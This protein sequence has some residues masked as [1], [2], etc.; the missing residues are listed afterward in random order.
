V[1]S[2]YVDLQSRL[3]NLE[4]AETQLVRILEEAQDTQDVLDVF[5]QLTSIREQ[6]EVVKGQIKYY[7]ESASLSAISIRV[8]AQEKVEPIKIGP[9][10]PT[11]A[12]NDAIE[13]LVDF[14]HSFVEVF[15]YFVFNF[16][17]ELLL[18]VLVYGVP[19]WLIV[20]GL[21]NWRRRIRAKQAPAVTP[22]KK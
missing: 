20:R 11:G 12:F 5:D 8:I 16:L 9:W 18:I 13:N 21:I 6:I 10:T 7:D 19:L 17:P 2:D 22:R 4:A 1:T 14:W 3:V 15:I